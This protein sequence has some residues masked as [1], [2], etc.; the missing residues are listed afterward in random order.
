MTERFYCYRKLYILKKQLKRLISYQSN[1]KCSLYWCS[2][3]QIN[4]HSGTVVS[5]DLNKKF[6]PPEEVS[7]HLLSSLAVL[8]AL[9]EGLPPVLRN[10]RPLYQPHNQPKSP[11]NTHFSKSPDKWACL[12]YCVLLSPL[13]VSMSGMTSLDQKKRGS[14][15]G[16]GGLSQGCRDNSIIHP[17]GGRSGGLS[18]WEAFKTEKKSCG[19]RKQ[20]LMGK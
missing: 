7:L 20:S 8:S 6:W 19:F 12:H 4:S 2:I 5:F 18:L 15:S 11:S 17:E 9:S 13:S 3:V 1:K 10:P 16:G 14:V